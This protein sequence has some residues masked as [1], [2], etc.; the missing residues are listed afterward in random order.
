[1]RHKEAERLIADAAYASTGGKQYKYLYR[2]CLE[3]DFIK[4]A[5]KRLRKGK[6]KRKEIKEIDSDLE[7]WIDRIREMLI[8]TKPCKVEHPEKA[9]SPKRKRPVYR[10]EHGK[11]RMIYMPDIIEQWIHHIIA[12]AL[13]P[14]IMRTAYRYSCGSLP[15]RGG[16]YGKKIVVKWIKS[17]KGIRHFLKIDIRHFYNNIRI[18]IL[19]RELRIHIR[20][21]WF[22][23]LVRKCFEG[24]KKGIA[25][26]F[27]IS[28]WLANYLLEPLDRYITEKLG[29]GKMVRYLDDIVIFSNSKKDLRKLVVLIKQ[30]IGRRFRLKLKRTWQICRFWY[31]KGTRKTRGKEKPRIIGRALD[32]MGFVFKRDRVGIRKRILLEARRTATKIRKS[33]EEGR[34]IFHK[35]A[36]AMISYMGWFKATDTKEYFKRWIKPLVKIGRLKAILS[37]LGARYKDI[38]REIRKDEKEVVQSEVLI[39]TDGSAIHK[40]K[41]WISGGWAYKIVYG[42][43]EKL[44]SGEMLKSTNNRA[45]MMAVYKALRAAESLKYKR[46]TII[47]DNNYVVNVLKGEWVPRSNHKLWGKIFSVTDKFKSIQFVW[48]KGHSGNKH[49]EDADKAANEAAKQAA[50]R[51]K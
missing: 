33:K 40:R 44:V 1:M 48:I 10:K 28:Q 34:A 19:M 39:Y 8:N 43:K 6:T 31:E 11:E 38:K 41:R 25:L 7:V 50:K 46:I 29:F 2:K 42:K 22:L 18:D 5:Y 12:L 47:C 51:L 21:E 30:F 15:K 24:F 35:H 26:G 17:G 23:Y 37:K 14:I 3:R 49:N 13:E 20:D 27:Y 9:F 16:H 32:F 45:E 36:S 4:R